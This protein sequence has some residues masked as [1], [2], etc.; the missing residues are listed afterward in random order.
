[1]HTVSHPTVF[2][3]TGL[4]PVLPIR[5]KPLTDDELAVQVAILRRRQ[6]KRQDVRERLIKY[7]IE[8]REVAR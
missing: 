2:P 5:P 4:V 3:A 1:M 7:A 8:R 6:L